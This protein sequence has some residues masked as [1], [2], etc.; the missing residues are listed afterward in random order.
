LPAQYDLLGPCVDRLASTRNDRT[1][2]PE[3]CLTLD[4]VCD[5]VGASL[6]TSNP[7]DRD[8]QGP[9]PD[10]AGSYEDGAR[11]REAKRQT[12]KI[13]TGRMTH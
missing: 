5:K 13:R 11:G 4:G 12:G 1:A 2:P 6:A 9:E 3:R 8:R 7:W 10:A